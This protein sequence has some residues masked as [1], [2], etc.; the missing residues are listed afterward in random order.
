MKIIRSCSPTFLS[1]T[2]QSDARTSHCLLHWG[3]TVVANELKSLFQINCNMNAASKGQSC[4][5]SMSSLL[6]YKRCTPS[7]QIS[8]FF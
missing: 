8:V 2:F 6:T 3:L 5:D 7:W 4:K 1:A